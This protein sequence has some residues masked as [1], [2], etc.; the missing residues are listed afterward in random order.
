MPSSSSARV[1]WDECELSVDVWNCCSEAILSGECGVAD[2]P[3]EEEEEIEEIPGIE[4]RSTER[5][6]E[7]RNLSGEWYER[8]E[9]EGGIPDCND[10]SIFIALPIPVPEARPTRTKNLR[11]EVF[12]V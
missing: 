7:Y 5:G 3:E 10:V 8:M 2:E 6:G 4:E 11:R 1:G 12:G 9:C